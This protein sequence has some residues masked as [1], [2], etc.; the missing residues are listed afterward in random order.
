MSTCLVT[1]LKEAVTDNSLLKIDELRIK[2]NKKG[3]SNPHIAFWI[4]SS[5][6]LTVIGSGYITNSAQTANYGTSKTVSSGWLDVYLSSDVKEI[7][8]ISKYNFSQLLGFNFNSYEFDIGELEYI[9]INYLDL[10]SATL[11]TGD[12]K[13]LKNK[14]L[15]ILYLFDTGVSGDISVLSSLSSTLTHALFH[16]S[17]NLEGDISSLSDCNNI[18]QFTCAFDTKI[19]GNI[20]ALANKTMLSLFDCNGSSVE[21]DISSFANDTALTSLNVSNTSITGDTSSLSALTNLTTFY[22]VNTA[23]T[24]TWPLS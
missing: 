5:T 12:I 17:Q 15:T 1:T 3:S 19:T 2:L 24:G 4:N 20:S 7:S 11:L 16:G 13:A 6:T 14:P 23:I 9:N 22:Y 10:G 8:L 18:V 21:G